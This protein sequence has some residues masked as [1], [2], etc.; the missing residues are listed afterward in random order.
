ML[1]KTFGRKLDRTEGAVL[2]IEKIKQQM[3]HG[4]IL[5]LLDN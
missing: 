1:T 4:I 2:T 3:D 5:L